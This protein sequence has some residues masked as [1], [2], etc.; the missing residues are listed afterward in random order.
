LV[1][2]NYINY[3]T[4]LT[5]VWLKKAKKE[6]WLKKIRMDKVDK[7][8]YYY[9]KHPFE[10]HWDKIEWVQHF[11]LYEKDYEIF[12]YLSMIFEY[13]S[14]NETVSACEKIEKLIEELEGKIPN[15][16]MKRA[17][18]FMIDIHKN[19]KDRIAILVSEKINK[20]L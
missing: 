1:E 16:I 18:L 17:I 4:P 2:K 13:F 8:K 11:P 20:V 9:I 19:H 14:L 12:H 6:D 3:C 7:E 10:Y 5:Y 15:E